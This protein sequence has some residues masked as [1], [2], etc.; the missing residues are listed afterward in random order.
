MDISHNTSQLRSLVLDI[1]RKCVSFMV[2]GGSE[3]VVTGTIALD[4]SMG[5]YLNALEN[6]IYDNP[7]L[8]DD[9]AGTTIAVHPPHFVLLPQE[10]VDAGMAAK[11]LEASFST[12]DGTVLA[13][14]IAGSTAAVACDIPRGV[15]AFLRRTFVGA[16]V[17]HHLVPLCGYCIGAYS[18][19]TGC[20]HISLDENS[21]HMVVVKQGELQMANSFHYRALEDVAYF[22]LNMWKASAL[23]SRHDKVL[24]SGD[25]SRRSSLA[26]Q[27]RQWLPYVMPDVLPSSALKFGKDAI[28][29]PF[30]L[31][32]LAIYE[33]N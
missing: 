22:A 9:Y 3:P 13:H 27:L 5:N 29:L 2:H 8:L 4:E 32:T 26:E 11:V 31:L 6:A 25:N 14:H 10:L 24:L 20:M 12:V 15:L 17:M 33:N 23:D 30:N 21:A 1:D 18:E 19:E 28:S 16:V 7:L